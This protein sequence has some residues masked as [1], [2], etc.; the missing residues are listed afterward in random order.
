MENSFE[1][2]EIPP[3]AGCYIIGGNWHIYLDNRPRWLT[4]V[5]MKWLLEW[6]WEDE[7]A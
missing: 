1:C 2:I 3:P 7:Q 5:L 4:R 6:E